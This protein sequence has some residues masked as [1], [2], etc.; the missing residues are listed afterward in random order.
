MELSLEGSGL[1]YVVGDALGVFPR[2]PEE[3]VDEI[4][5]GLPFNGSEEVPLPNGGE[6]SLREALITAYDIRS[7]TP[8]SLR[9][10]QKRSGSPCLRSLVESEDRKAMKDY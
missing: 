5:S 1:E 9:A 4:L 3:Q 7:L 6:A 10:W 2:N 8:K